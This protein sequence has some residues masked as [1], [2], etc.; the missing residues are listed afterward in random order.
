MNLLEIRKKFK[1]LSGRYDLVNEDGSDR[2]ATYFINEACRWL[3]K[4]VEV[5]RTYGKYAEVLVAGTWNVQLNGCRAIKEAWLTTSGG[6]AQ[7][8]K[9]SIQ[10]MI[11]SYYTKLPADIEDGTPDKYSPAIVRNF[12]VDLTLPTLMAIQAYTGIITPSDEDYNAI[13]LSCP[14]EEESLIE[15]V[16][17]FYSRLLSEDD[18]VN[19]WTVSNSL[20]LISTAIKMTYMLSGNKPMSDIL[21]KGINEELLRL[22]KE[23]IESEIAEVNQME[24]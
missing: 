1:D 4:T 13:L 22:D 16:G 8:T 15:I 5:E 23:I 11:A 19:Y 10:D 17:F 18:D 24:G 20:L 7:L 3:D 14:L 2:G 12:F 21:E 9:I 6:K